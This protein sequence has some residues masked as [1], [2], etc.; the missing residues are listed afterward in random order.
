MQIIIG[1]SY[2]A[3]YQRA[4]ARCA[5]RMTV[6]R[7]TPSASNPQTEDQ[8]VSCSGCDSYYS[9]TVNKNG[10]EMPT[11]LRNASAYYVQQS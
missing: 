10:D 3:N 11:Q 7:R 1:A 6:V 8:V 4:C 9:R 5:A 2:G